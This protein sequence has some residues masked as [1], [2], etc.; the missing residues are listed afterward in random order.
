MRNNH[1]L[2]AAKIGI[3]V[4]IAI[5][6]LF[7]S[8]SAKADV[9]W[10]FNIGVPGV[11]V[12]APAPTY[13]VPPPVYVRPAPPVIYLPEPEQYQY[14]NAV[15]Y[16]PPPPAYFRNQY[17]RERHEHAWRRHEDDDRE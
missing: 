2:G 7:L 14:G 8:T 11:V 5:A 3:P 9:D 10:Y 6:A 17:W 13:V 12:P 1:Y 4:G 15:P 16:G